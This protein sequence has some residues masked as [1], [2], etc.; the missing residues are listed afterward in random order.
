MKC[1]PL[2]I[3]A[4]AMPLALVACASTRAA[5]Q[6]TM[7]TARSDAV[8]VTSEGRARAMPYAPTGTAFDVRLDQP[9][10]TRLS[11]P[12]D[13]VSAT[14][15]QPILANNS[16]ALVPAGTQLRGRVAA[17]YH[18]PIPRIELAFHSLA[19]RGGPVPVGIA[20]LAL[21]ESHYRVLPATPG[22]TSMQPATGGACS[23]CPQ[24]TDQISLAKG[25]V[26]K[27][28]LTS[29]IIEGRPLE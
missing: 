27:V 9:V 13:P 14:L 10:D 3:V 12:G 2:W 1:R 19:L 15:L 25:S 29:P 26:L 24:G 22:V 8:L 5:P 4:S 16:D 7:L 21:Q 6:S 23:G 20:V 28:V 18:D 17:I 11:A